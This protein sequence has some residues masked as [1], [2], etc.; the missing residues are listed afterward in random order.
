MGMLTSSPSVF[1]AFWA[2]VLFSL[3]R[4][5]KVRQLGWVAFGLLAILSGLVFVIS[6]SDVGWRLETRVRKVSNPK[7]KDGT[8]QI[9]MTY[10]QYGEERLPVYEV[11]PSTP[12][13]FG[14]KVA[15]A[16]AYRAKLRDEEFLNDYA[17]LSFVRVVV[18]GYFLSFL[19]P[20][21]TLAYAS[22]AMG[23]ER[24]G[25]T[26][27]WL[28][29]RPLPRWAVYL[30]KYLGTMP[31]CI[32]VCGLAFTAMCLCGGELGRHALWL[33]WPAVL[34]GSVAFGSLFHLIGAIFRW[35]AV[36][37]LVYVF[38]F[39]LLVGALPGS[40]KQLSLSF[41]VRSL[42]YN[43]TASD[44]ASVKPES[45]DVFAP[46]DPT[47]AWFTLILVSIVLTLIGMWLFGRQEPKDGS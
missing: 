24:D 46:T 39:E 45:V 42:F 14:L 43:E 1:R 35:P 36:V 8:E 16:S 18:F 22:G 23:A 38:F 21:L 4:H 19:L 34:A 44:I 17:T 2:L 29:T 26:L 12:E 25:R 20:L 10:R 40:L 3:Q 32:G 7:D 13:G 27:I 47:T 11:F 5:G 28:L 37:G 6:H 15:V 31:W 33:H 41:Y 30:A 9:A